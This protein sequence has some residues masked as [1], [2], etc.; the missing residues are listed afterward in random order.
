MNF[1]VRIKTF[2]KQKQFDFVDRPTPCGSFAFRQ[3][4]SHLCKIPKLACT[5]FIVRIKTFAEQKQFDFV[6]R[7]TSLRLICL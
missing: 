1:I 5:H 7:P 4:T 6:D 2:T 3:I